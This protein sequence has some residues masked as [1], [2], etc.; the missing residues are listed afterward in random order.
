[1]GRGQSR[2]LGGAILQEIIRRIDP[3][4]LKIEK[5]RLQGPVIPAFRATNHQ[6]RDGGV[7]LRDQ[8]IVLIF[9]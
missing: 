1:V 2:S 6:P 4:T 5:R 9:I 7:L 8:K 3:L